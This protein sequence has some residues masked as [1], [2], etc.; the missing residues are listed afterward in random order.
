VT[1]TAEDPAGPTFSHVA[2]GHTGCP[3]A[4]VHVGERPAEILDLDGPVAVSLG[5]RSVQGVAGELQ[6][7]VAASQRTPHYESAWPLSS[8]G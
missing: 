7:S 3:P 6:H 2:G 4:A 5:E 1:G 8:R